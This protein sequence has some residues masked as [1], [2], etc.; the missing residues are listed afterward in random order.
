M[1]DAFL[2][3]CDDIKEDETSCFFPSLFI[4]FLPYEFQLFLLGKLT[5]YVSYIWK[6]MKSHD[7]GFGVVVKFKRHATV[8][9]ALFFFFW[10]VCWGGGGRFVCGT[11]M[12]YFSNMIVIVAERYNL[13]PC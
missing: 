12:V 4:Y 9:E 3:L 7:F 6:K 11:S 10:E 2:F 5:S 1:T 8:W 13:Q